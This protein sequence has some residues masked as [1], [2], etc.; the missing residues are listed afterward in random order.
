ME[1]DKIRAE[2]EA[3]EYQER[4]R[5]EAIEISLYATEVLFSVNISNNFP[6]FTKNID[7]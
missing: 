7:I 2:T 6:F 4:F 3:L 5:F 1:F